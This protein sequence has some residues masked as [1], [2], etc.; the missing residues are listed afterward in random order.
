MI[1]TALG[2]EGKTCSA[3]Q[4]GAL[5]FLAFCLPFDS[6]AYRDGNGSDAHDAASASLSFAPRGPRLH[7]R[8][9][10]KHR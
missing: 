8:G 3:A 2:S 9:T 4:S 10:P 6:N 5:A 1:K 7:E